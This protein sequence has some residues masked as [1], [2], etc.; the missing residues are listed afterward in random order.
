MK[1]IDKTTH[2]LL[3]DDGDTECNSYLT[4]R[5]HYLK[6]R[7]MIVDEVEI[8]NAGIRPP[9][10]TRFISESNEFLGY[11]DGFY[12]KSNDDN[13]RG[14]GIE[15]LLCDMMVGAKSGMH[16]VYKTIV[17][18]RQSTPPDTKTIDIPKILNEQTA[19]QQSLIEYTFDNTFKYAT[20][21]DIGNYR[22]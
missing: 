16:R 22:H 8:K 12:T 5:E 13:C 15:E 20:K 9:E 18:D 14:L 3:L 21:Q 11:T 19:R 10:I 1:N 4:L 2:S 6:L 7:K 17:D